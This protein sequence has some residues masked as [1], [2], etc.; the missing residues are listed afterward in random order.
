MFNTD[1]YRLSSPDEL[2]FPI[3]ATD[4]EEDTTEDGVNQA[5]REKKRIA[6]LTQKDAN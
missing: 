5:Y 6:V 1:L 3:M 2:E 4:E